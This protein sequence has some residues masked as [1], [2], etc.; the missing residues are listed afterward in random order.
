MISF[1][2]YLIEGV[3]NT[4]TKK[5]GLSPTLKWNPDFYS[6]KPVYKLTGDEKVIFYHIK[7]KLFV[8]L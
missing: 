7:Q 6:S 3:Y 1:S 5:E 4:I 2:Q 8:F